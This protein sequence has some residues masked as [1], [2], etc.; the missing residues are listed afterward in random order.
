MASAYE[1]DLSCVSVMG[2][3]CVVCGLGL[4]SDHVNADL[5]MKE[6]EQL[7]DLTDAPGGAGGAAGGAA[8]AGGGG[9]GGAAASNKPIDV[10]LDELMRL[11]A[12]QRH[13]HAAAS[14]NPYVHSPS[15]R[16]LYHC[17]CAN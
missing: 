2:V 8:A 14:T 16:T 3:W 11:A 10:D 1:S 12:D 17:F 7:L 13:Q 9:G 15:H 5:S 4:T 6:F